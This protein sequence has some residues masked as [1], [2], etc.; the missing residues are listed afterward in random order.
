M[1]TTNKKPV[2]EG[3]GIPYQIDNSLYITPANQLQDFT[4][5]T[6]ENYPTVH[7]K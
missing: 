6:H 3:K 4:N 5:P 1:H 7:S 2:T